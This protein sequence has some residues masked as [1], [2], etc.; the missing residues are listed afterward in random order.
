MNPEE[1]LDRLI[2][3]HEQGELHVP[4]I[5]DDFASSLVAAETLVQLKEISIPYEFANNLELSIRAHAHNLKEQNRGNISIAQSH[6]LSDQNRRTNPP[7]RSHSPVDP[8]PHFKR[9][10]WI[11]FL[12]VAAVL[13]I[14]GVGIL[15]ASARSQPGDA[16]YG[17]SQAEKQ[18]ALT[19]A[20]APQ[21]HANL[22]I[23]QLRNAIVDLKT[24][25]NEGRDD[26]TIRLAIDTVAAKTSDSQRA[27]A[28]L[29]MDSMRDEAQRSLSSALAEEEQI[30]YALL[31][32]V[33]WPVR[34]AFTQQLGTLGEPVP[35]VTNV[36]VHTQN[37]GT[38]LIT[39]SGTHFASQAQLMI[40]GLQNGKVS[41]STPTQLIAFYSNTVSYSVAYAIGVMNPDGT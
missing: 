37:N 32:N 33:D 29:Q 36:V 24:A 17:L 15:T 12:R 19:F 27:V 35:T 23:D 2:E 9:R 30:L 41:Q 26:G 39:L 40:D 4:A 31:N 16:L 8:H 10:A 11:T 20:G 14:A 25:V 28:A 1:Y 21:N 38:F 34:L 6:I 13:I 18:F 22:Q 3:L 7:V 5:N